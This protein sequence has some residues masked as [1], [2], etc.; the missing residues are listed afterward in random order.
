VLLAQKELFQLGNLAL[1]TDKV[2]GIVAPNDTRTA[3][4]ADVYTQRCD[5]RIRREILDHFQ[6]SDNAAS[7]ACDP[8]CKYFSL[9]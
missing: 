9:K 5:E 1:C 6:L 4:K 7:S 2:C 8:P 3:S